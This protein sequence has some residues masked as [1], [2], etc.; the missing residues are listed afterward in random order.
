[1]LSAQVVSMEVVTA[2]GKAMKVTDTQHHLLNAFR[3]SYGILRIIYEVTLPVRPIM[4]FAAG[5]R[6]MD[7]DTFAGF[8][9]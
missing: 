2:D 8:S 6:S 1:M 7:V 9:D 4:A 3:L 5:H